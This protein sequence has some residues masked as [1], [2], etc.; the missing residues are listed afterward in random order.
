VRPWAMV[1]AMRHLGGHRASAAV[2]IAAVT[3]AGCSAADQ[4]DDE[5]AARPVP[6]SADTTDVT[7]IE[8]A[9]GLLP[10]DVGVIEFSSDRR[11]TER[12]GLID[13][14]ATTVAELGAS[15]ADR[16]ADVDRSD[17]AA[18]GSLSDWV[19]EMT[20]GGATFSQV[21]VRWSMSAST[22]DGLTADD[23]RHVQAF[24]LVDGIDMADVVDD[25]EDAGFARTSD[26]GWERFH[27]DGQLSESVDVL[28][29][30]T[31][32][33]RFPE[34]FFPDVSVH[35]DAHL[36][37]L[38]DVDVLVPDGSSGEVLAAL[39]PFLPAAKD[40]VEHVALT[41]YQ[42][43]QCYAAVDK[44]TNYRTTPAKLAAWSER[45]GIEDLGVPAFTMLLWTPGDDV[46]HRSFYKDESTAQRALTGR[47]RLYD[48]AARTSEAALGVLMPGDGNESPYEPGW[49]MSREGNVVT[50]LHN[51]TNPWDAVRTYGLHGLG[52]D[53][54][55]APGM[56]S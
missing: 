56:F 13:D 33:G 38:G 40:D 16:E 37:A 43:M 45:F 49:R 25:L 54:C 30:N 32:D 11:S 44:A 2:L 52:F 24:R 10:R 18:I 8:E 51:A 35:P 29:G 15:Y 47:A 23:H 22:G 27:L 21:D 1:R 48:G 55:G 42:Y 50:V 7:P 17:L 34:D 12:L 41:S 6:V 26:D 36:V 5:D 39:G 31:I 28:D 9:L 53:A 3:L 14:G 19:E 46:I 20:E 4:S